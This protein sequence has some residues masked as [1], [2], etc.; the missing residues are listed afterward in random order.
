MLY[1][2]DMFLLYNKMS[3][4]DM[5][6]TVYLFIYLFVCFLFWSFVDEVTFVTFDWCY[7][8]VL[9]DSQFS[10]FLILYLMFLIMF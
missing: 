9:F 5:D 8:L 1:R 10:F 4:C 2:L 6:L 7:A 3:S